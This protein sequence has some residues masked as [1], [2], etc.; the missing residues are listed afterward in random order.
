MDIQPHHPQHRYMQHLMTYYKALHRANVSVD[1]VSEEQDFT[2]YK[3]LIA[4]LQF[5]MTE[6]HAAK[7]KAYVAQGGHLVISWRSGVKDA[8]SLCHTQGA[9]PCMV[10]D[11]FGVAVSEYDC[12]RD[13]E[14]I[15]RW[16]GADYPCKHWCDVLE[17]SAEPV[18]AY[19][20][21]FYAGSPAITRNPWGKGCAWYVGTTMGEAL[22]DKFVSVIC[23]EAE[24]KSLMATPHGVE[25]VHRVKDGRRY[26]FVLN[27]NEAAKQLDIPAGYR[28]WDG[29]AWDGELPALG[30]Q[31]FIEE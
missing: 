5:L 24:V 19:A 7:L 11:L 28:T 13:T 22:A 3:V 29:A 18:A 30:V 1:F 14:G 9:V 17:A 26:L 31:V 15:V 4:P 6:A 27:H 20:H 25:A 8:T 16:D 23:G 21:E 2:P 12:L 10:D